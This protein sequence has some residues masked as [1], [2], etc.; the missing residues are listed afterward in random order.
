MT[1]LVPKS[2]WKE[3]IRHF[4]QVKI[5]T[6][7]GIMVN[8][9]L[10]YNGPEASDIVAMI[11]ETIFEP[12]DCNVCGDYYH[13]S[14]TSR[15]R[16]DP[17]PHHLA[18]SISTSELAERATN[19]IRKLCSPAEFDAWAKQIDG[20]GQNCLEAWRKRNGRMAKLS[21]L[22]KLFGFK[23]YSTTDTFK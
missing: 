6:E 10:D 3:L 16:R 17:M 20:D 13:W 2:Q 23:W 21:E 11:Y 9:L 5:R 14:P 8:D 1:R 15:R 19:G 18:Q 22:E 7:N 12:F 4:V